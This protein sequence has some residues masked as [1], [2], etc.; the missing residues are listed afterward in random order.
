MKQGDKVKELN[1][2]I[3]LFESIGANNKTHTT[4]QTQRKNT[5]T[6]T[7]KEALSNH[8]KRGWWSA[9]RRGA[10]GEKRGSERTERRL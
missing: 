3:M 5:H 9:W 2:T 10:M 7:A 4:P 1:A 6:W 8:Q